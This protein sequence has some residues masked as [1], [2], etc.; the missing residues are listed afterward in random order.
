M[1]GRGCGWECASEVV[2]DSDCWRKIGEVS[3]FSIVIGRI[4]S[5]FTLVLCF[6]RFF[7]L[8]ALIFR[9]LSRGMV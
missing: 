1:I 9:R 2:V 3:N 6:D 4:V 5:A 8:I 7:G